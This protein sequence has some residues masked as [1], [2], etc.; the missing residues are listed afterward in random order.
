MKG[1]RPSCVITGS[2]G[3]IG[4]YLVARLRSQGWK[5]IEWCE[6]V[7]NL[8]DCDY[9]AWVVFHLAAKT[10]HEQFQRNPAEAYDVN[11]SGTLAV[12]NYCKR[13]GAKCIL[14]STSGIYKPSTDGSSVQETAEA[15]PSQPYAMSKW[16]AENLCCQQARTWGIPTICL[17]LFNVYGTEQHPDFLVPYILNCLLNEQPI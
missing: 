8:S 1:D 16:I 5:V 4:R 2:Q 14:A 7:R 13:H 6:D 10:R 15:F 12:L 11:I 3:F 17:R 9:S